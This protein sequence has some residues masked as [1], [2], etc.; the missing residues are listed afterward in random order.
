[1]EKPS[2]PYSDIPAVI[3]AQ[4]NTDSDR[5]VLV[6]M[7]QLARRQKMLRPD[8]T[9]EQMADYLALAENCGNFD[10]WL[11]LRHAAEAS[12]QARS[13]LAWLLGTLCIVVLLTTGLII[14]I[15]LSVSGL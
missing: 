8:I 10:Q 13:T 9:D 2:F 14:A 1:M 6:R 4:L 5:D 15:A 11:K 7:E 3:R 12:G